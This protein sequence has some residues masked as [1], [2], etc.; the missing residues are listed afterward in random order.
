M[1]EYI[2]IRT[3][4]FIA[5]LCILGLL[6]CVMAFLLFRYHNR[7]IHLLDE[8]HSMTADLEGQ[9]EKAKAAAK[10]KSDFLSHMSH[11]IRTPLNAIVGM[12][13]IAQD[14]ANCDRIDDCLKEMGYYSKHLLGIVNDILDFSKM[15]SGGFAFEEKPF[16]LIGE[17][18]F[19]AS[20]FK[21][22]VAEKDLTL[23][24]EAKDIQHD[25]IFTDKLRLNQVLINLLS[26][27]VKFTDSGGTVEL[28][29]EEVLHMNCE[30]VYRFIVRDDGIGIE[31]EQ[32]KKLF[33]PFTQANAGVTRLYGGTGLGLAISQNIVQMMGGDIEL[34]TEFGKGSTFRFTIRVPAEEKA[35]A[36]LENE[37]RVILPDKLRGKRIMVVDDIATNRKVVELLLKGSGVLIDTAANGKEA[38]DAFCGAEPH[39]Y[40]LILMDMLMPV[41]DGCTATEKIRNS[42]KEDAHDIKIIAMTANVMRE[43]VE[44]AYQS[45]M[46]GHLAKPIDRTEL[47][48][49]MEE[50]LCEE[51]MG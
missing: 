44:R 46:D 8:L 41:M 5:L 40:D 24:V 4:W 47:Y 23:R 9:V 35:I 32:A 22:K 26:N 12:V 18:D 34:E 19:I 11:E 21:A 20:M 38:L 10:A 42:G 13:Q 25:V 17:I 50:W 36:P 29:V 51:V 28:T 33:T 27:A 37:P 31:P 6:V 15:E 1:S 2:Q 16:S 7:C 3:D 45:G 48:T 49:R 14:A 39:W 30:S 43:D